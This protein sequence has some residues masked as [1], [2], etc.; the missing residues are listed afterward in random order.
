MTKTLIIPGNIPERNVASRPHW[1]Q[2]WAL[3]DP[4]ALVVA[5]EPWAPTA[6]DAW[7]MQVAGAILAHP[8]AILVGHGYGAIV[9]ARLLTHWPQLQVAGALLVAPADASGAPLPEGCITVPTLLVASRNDP[10]LP[11]AAAERQARAWGVEAVDIGHAGHIDAAAGFGPWPEGIELR[12]GLL[13]GRPA[14]ASRALGA[15]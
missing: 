4:A 7:E 3:R 1:Q 8:G 2:W 9:A 10:Y 6:P 11:F 5:D 13:A 14:G 12:D 15:G